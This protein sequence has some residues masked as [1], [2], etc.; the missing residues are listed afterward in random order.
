MH[1]AE[2]DGEDIEGFSHIGMDIA[3]I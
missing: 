2:I 3:I 1:N